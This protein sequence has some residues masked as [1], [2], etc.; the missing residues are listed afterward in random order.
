VRLL[1]W[2]QGR[3][4]GGMNHKERRDAELAYVADES[5]Y[6]EMLHARELLQ[7]LNFM[8]HADND[9][10]KVALSYAKSKI[11]DSYINQR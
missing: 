11:Y 8:D 1:S 3:G 7:K 5:L 9:G 2:F 10:I 6:E 4:N